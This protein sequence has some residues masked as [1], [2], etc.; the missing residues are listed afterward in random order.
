MHITNLELILILFTTTNV[1]AYLLG[2]WH[3]L[4]RGR[5]ALQR[6]GLALERA[7]R[8]DCERS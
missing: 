7:D 2:R 6:I 1:T 4:R 5:E 3:G 8:P